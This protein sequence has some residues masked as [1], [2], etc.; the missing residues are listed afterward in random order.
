MNPLYLLIMLK[1]ENFLLISDLEKFW[2][3]HSYNAF[4]SSEET[5]QLIFDLSRVS[6][7]TYTYHSVVGILGNIL[8]TWDANI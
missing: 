7:S 8:F 2:L 4:K 5:A 3:T 6:C 1:A